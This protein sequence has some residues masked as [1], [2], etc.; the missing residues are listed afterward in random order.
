MRGALP[1]D[2]QCQLAGVPIPVAEYR[3]H[4]TRRWQFDQAW[5]A[6]LIAVEIDGGGF[7]QGRH[8]RGAGV[9]KDCEKFCEAALLGWRI[10]RVTPRMV[11]DGRALG[12][13]ERFLGKGH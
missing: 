9:E 8:S 10:F 12:Y 3:F 5:P 1:L 11:R 6:L 2:R 4:P 7:V 13:L